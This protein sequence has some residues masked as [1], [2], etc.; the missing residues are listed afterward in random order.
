MPKGVIIIFIFLFPFFIVS[1]TNVKSFFL[2]ENNK[3]IDSL[4]YSKKCNTYYFKCLDYNTDTLKLKKVLYRFSFGKLKEDEIN[5]IRNLLKSDLNFNLKEG[6]SLVVK[7]RD[8]ILAFPEILKRYEA[9][10]KI[11]ESRNTMGSYVKHKAFNKKIHKSRIKHW[12]K[13]KNKCFKKFKK[14]FPVN[15]LYVYKHDKGGVKEYENF[16]W[17]EDIRKLLKNRFF[18]IMYNYNLL[19]IKPDGNYFLSGGHF[20]DNNLKKLLEVSDWSKF[21]SDFNAFKNKYPNKGF[22]IFKKPIGY[23]HISHCF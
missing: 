17:N 12:V 23:T 5:Q 1:Q 14:K 11:H 9:H 21:L 19:V 8:T 10:V 4:T 18:K 20:S 13:E 16:S 6:E 22:G 7:F 3:E 2:D 15:F